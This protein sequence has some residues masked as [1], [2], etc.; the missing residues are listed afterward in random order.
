MDEIIE[1]PAVIKNN[2]T[3]KNA[4]ET[5]MQ[6]NKTTQPDITLDDLTGNMSN[7]IVF[8]P[9]APG[10]SVLVAEERQ[11]A[12]TSVAYH[13]TK[14]SLASYNGQPTNQLTQAWRNY[15][16]SE[17]FNAS[18]PS[19]DVEAVAQSMMRLGQ[20]TSPVTRLPVT[21]NAFLIQLN[22]ISSWSPQLTPGQTP[23]EISK[24]LKFEEDLFGGKSA[25]DFEN[26][27]RSRSIQAIEAIGLVVQAQT[28][29]FTVD[30]TTG[31]IKPTTLGQ[32]MMEGLLTLDSFRVNAIGLGE[33][34]GFYNRDKNAPG[35]AKHLRED[36]DT[37]F[38]AINNIF[39]RLSSDNPKDVVNDAKTFV[40][41]YTSVTGFNVDP[42]GVEAT[43]ERYGQNETEFEKNELAAKKK[44][45]E[46]LAQVF[47]DLASGN[48]E[49][50]NA[51]RVKYLNYVIAYS[52]AS[53]LQGGTGGRTISDQDVQN[54]LNFLQVGL[55]DPKKEYLVLQELKETLSYIAQRGAAL[56]SPN[57][58]T[59]FDAYIHQD[60][61]SKAD[62]RVEDRLVDLI[63]DMRVPDRTPKPLAGNALELNPRNFSPEL[64]SYIVR[65]IKTR[66]LDGSLPDLGNPG[67]ANY[68][69][70]AFD[71]LESALSLEELKDEIAKSI[72][73]AQTSSN[74]E[75]RNLVAPLFEN[76]NQE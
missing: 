10:S 55:G 59:K 50:I 16:P 68:L 34:F 67:D 15:H 24:F 58:Q 72:R 60:M 32:G 64:K 43:A 33:Y 30:P 75:V 65:T 4:Y 17:S 70:D 48:Q 35:L 2:S 66:D 73:S 9:F 42:A 53:A 5:M 6:W 21:D 12:L 61:M 26:D 11:A 40:D 46:G 39:D 44:N 56:S 54:V 36:S 47:Q 19:G 23:R 69:D 7:M 41:S 29:K 51:A 8:Q 31:V 74:E 45:E 49:L 27:Q 13:A 57:P 22:A 1:I 71:T 38:G 14:R 28:A 63:N 18:I 37:S 3:N 62:I 52:V 76:K 20:Q 25:V